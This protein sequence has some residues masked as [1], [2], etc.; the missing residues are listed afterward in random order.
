MGDAADAARPH[1][2]H[3]IA[4]LDHV[5]EGCGELLDLLEEQR[6]ELPAA[7]YSAAE[8]TAV[9]A[10]DGRLA[11]GVDLGHAQRIGPRQ[12]LAEIVDEIAGAGVAM[13]LEHEQYAPSG[14]ALAHRL[15]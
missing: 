13:R 6:L 8:G 5:P 7:A 9:G 15:Q 2:D 4:P 10:G 1:R 3:H 11:R 12:R 14:V